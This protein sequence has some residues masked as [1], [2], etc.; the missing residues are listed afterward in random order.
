LQ[1]SIGRNP[2]AA[3]ADAEEKIARKAA[4]AERAKGTPIMDGGDF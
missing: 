3:W 1:I 2:E 4:A